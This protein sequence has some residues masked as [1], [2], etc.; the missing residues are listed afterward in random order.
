MS[1]VRVGDTEEL[2]RRGSWRFT[3][4]SHVEPELALTFYDLYEASFG[5]LRVQALARQVLTEAE[6]HAQ[7]ADGAVMKYVAWGDDDRPVGLC[8]LTNRLE[9]VPWISSEYFADRYPDHWQRNAV[10]Y[11]GFVLTHPTERRSRFVDQLVEVGIGEL[12]EQHAIC[13]WDMCVYNDATL[14]IGPRLVE[15]FERLTGVTARLADTQNY[16]TLDL[17]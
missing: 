8:T 10:W 3:R 14:G 1:L 6:F 11:F 4:T 12:V 2:G 5:P 7:M 9:T 17:T 16:Y 13:A 15:S